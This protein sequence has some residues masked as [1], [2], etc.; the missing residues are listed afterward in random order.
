[1]YG[2]SFVIY[3]N[4]LLWFIVLLSGQQL[5]EPQ[6]NYTDCY[7]SHDFRPSCEH[8]NH[9]VIAP[10]ANY[11]GAKLISLRC[12]LEL[13]PTGSTSVDKDECCKPDAVGHCIDEYQY[14]NH[15][16]YSFSIGRSISEHP[17]A[18]IRDE[19]YNVCN[20]TGYMAKTTFMYMEYYCIASTYM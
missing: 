9:T 3:Q 17:L 16:L 18:V 15:Q 4:I 12:P 14:P 6:A 5:P 2:H 13:D 20:E 7:G 8:L 10:K 19:T 11:I 1:M